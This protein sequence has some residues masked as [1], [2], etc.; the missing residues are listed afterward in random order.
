MLTF[1]LL[2]LFGLAIG[3][4]LGAVGAGGSILAVPVLGYVAGEP[5]KQA[6]VS[7][8][9]VVFTTSLIALRP[10]WVAKRVRLDLAVPFAATGTAGAFVGKELADGLD[11]NLLML[12]FAGLMV[13]SATLMLRRLQKSGSDSPGP[14]VHAGGVRPGGGGA[15]VALAG[16]ERWVGLS[17]AAKPEVIAKALAV[18]LG[19]GVL[20]GFFGVGGGFV[21]VPALVLVLGVSIAEAVGTSLAIIVVNTLVTAAMKAPGTAVDL[22]TVALFAGAAALGAVFG[23]RVSSRCSQATLTRWFASGVYAIAA[24]TAIRS[25]ASR[26]G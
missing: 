25:V 5:P 1:A 22:P 3:V 20:T 19:V 17:A 23:G 7:A 2:V 18:G 24:Y 10:H 8:L 12:A 14:V 4:S 26:L 6:T 9:L 13:L 11:S 16:E 21:I 15:L